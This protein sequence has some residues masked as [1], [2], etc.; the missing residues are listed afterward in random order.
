MNRKPIFDTVRRLLGRGFTKREVRMLDEAIDRAMRETGEQLAVEAGTKDAFARALPI[1]LE[2]EGGYVNHPQDP[3]G[4]TNLGV[5][6]RVW[7]AWTGTKASESV[8]RGLTVDDV[9]P[10][11][12][13]NYWDAVKGDELPAGVALSVFDFGVNA[14]PARAARYLQI[15]V[16]AF[17]DGKIGPETLAK[18]KEYTERESQAALVRE[19]AQ[20]RRDYYRRLK[21]FPTFGR[22]WLRRV[23]HIEAESLKLT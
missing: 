12:R 2:Q 11:Y 1:L 13:K 16:G 21:T 3:G 5:T 22:G 15:T 17:P 8:M 10:L 14:G 18:V 20:H 4:R 9:A 19:Y 23:E 6:Q 7:E